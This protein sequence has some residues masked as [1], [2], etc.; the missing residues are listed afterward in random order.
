MTT[1][2]T[3]AEAIQEAYKM[4]AD[5]NATAKDQT[6]NRGYFFIS[7]GAKNKMFTLWRFNPIAIF[8]PDWFIKSLSNDIIKA[9]EDAIT[10]ASAAGITL[11]IEEDQV[12]D[13]AKAYHFQ[14][15]KYKGELIDDVAEKDPRY[16]LWFINSSYEY[17]SKH[18]TKLSNHA[19]YALNLQA[20]AI[21]AVKQQ[22]I[23]NRVA[24]FGSSQFI[25]TVNERRDFTLTI[26]KRSIVG[27]MFGTCYK[28]E[29]LDSNNN[30]VIYSGSVDLT[31]YKDADGYI[32]NHEKGTQITFKATIK[33]HYEANG[34]KQ[35]YV[36]RPKM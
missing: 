16:L 25:G 33:S 34:V 14:F 13:R 17:A 4:I 22:N 31:E 18:R 20:E 9:V 1:L 29:M 12:G 23:A 21:A 11:D 6:E 15:G 8:K 2:S 26:L 19:V 3:P 28:I 36:T 32:K 10:I 35:T 5:Y 24:K 30:L 7:T 27:S